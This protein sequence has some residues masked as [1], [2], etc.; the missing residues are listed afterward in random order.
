MQMADEFHC[1]W[2]IL[3]QTFSRKVFYF[4]QNLHGGLKFSTWITSEKDE[5]IYFLV[6][7]RTK[8]NLFHWKKYLV[9]PLTQ[10]V[11]WTVQRLW[12]NEWLSI[13]PKVPLNLPE[14]WNDHIDST[15]NTLYFTK[16]MPSTSKLSISWKWHCGYFGKLEGIFGK[17]EINW[18]N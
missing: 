10:L 4:A 1:N 14:I 13:L 16:S 8:M 7:L 3:F 6:I 12:F 2:C 15:K 9:E 17:I 5:Q 11:D 18:S